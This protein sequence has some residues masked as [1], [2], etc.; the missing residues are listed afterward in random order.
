MEQEQIKWELEVVKNPIKCT[1]DK[2]GVYVL[3]GRRSYVECTQHK[4]DIRVDIMA[5]KGDLPVH[6]FVGFGNDVRKRV[7]AWLFDYCTISNEHASYIGY[8]ICRAMMDEK[9]VQV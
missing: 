7:I 1:I 9:F 3:I 4:V 8:E 2:S 6:S 5:T